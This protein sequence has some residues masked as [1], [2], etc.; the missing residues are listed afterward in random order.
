M[1]TKPLIVVIPGHGGW[2][3]DRDPRYATAPSKMVR[4]EEPGDLGP[5]LHE[6]IIEDGVQVGYF[7]EGVF[8]RQVVGICVRKMKE[9]GFDVINPLAPWRDTSLD[10][11][12]AIIDKLTE[13]RPGFLAEFHANAGRGHGSEIFTTRGETPSDA[14]ASRFMENLG[15]ASENRLPVRADYFSDGD[16]DKEV[17]FKVIR[18]VQAPAFLFEAG[19][20]DNRK[21]L[22]HLLDS[23]YH[24]EIA[25]A[26]CMTTA[27]IFY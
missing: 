11:R 3:C 27:D 8:N 26:L 15:I 4:I 22:Y 13:G 19:F 6:L 17:N 7:Y 16:V 21:D 18:S 14:I 24:H 5:Y 20:M 25:T 23:D 10:A 9:C 12:I 1:N 2:R